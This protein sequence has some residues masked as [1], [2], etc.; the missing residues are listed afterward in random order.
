MI[1][2]KKILLDKIKSSNNIF[3]VG[4][5]EEEE[6]NIVKAQFFYTNV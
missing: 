3:L 6:K 4:H 1:L 5:L 2:V